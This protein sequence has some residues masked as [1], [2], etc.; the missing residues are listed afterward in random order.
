MRGSI[1]KEICLFN[2]GL[3]NDAVIITDY[4]VRNNEVI[5]QR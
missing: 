3:F 1:P 4:I 5:S 2:D